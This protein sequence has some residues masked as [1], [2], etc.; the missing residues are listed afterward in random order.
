MEKIA[1]VFQTTVL[2]ADIAKEIIN[3]PPL[4]HAMKLLYLKELEEQS[5]GLC[6]T[7]DA[8]SI[9]K[10]GSKSYKELAI[11]SFKWAKL[12]LEWEEKAPDVLDAVAAV[13]VPENA[14]SQ[15]HRADAL[16][17][18]ICTALS[19][20][21]NARDEKMS[22]VQKLVTVIVGLGGCSKMVCYWSNIYSIVRQ[23]KGLCN[24]YQ[25]GRGWKMG[26]MYIR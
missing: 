20:L 2:P 21:L 6:K 26:F 16:I 14:L 15:S 13:A 9:L 18:P 5:K 4:K 3:I 7:K 8:S 22:L 25:G 11:V 19:I 23:C 17:P 12:L 24:N 1:R 10:V